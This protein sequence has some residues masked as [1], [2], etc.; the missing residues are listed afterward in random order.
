MLHR[1]RCGIPRELRIL[2][3]ICSLSGAKTRSAL[4]HGSGFCAP[5]K[6][7][8]GAPKGA[9]VVHSRALAR[10][11]PALRQPV[12]LTALHCGVIRWWD[13]SA[14]PACPG[15]LGPDQLTRRRDGRFHPGLHDEPGGLLHT[16][17]GSRLAK[18]ARG[19][20]SPFTSRIACRTPLKRTGRSP[21]YGNRK[22]QSRRIMG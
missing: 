13:P 20:P 21:T 6:R 5:F 10:H 4:L 18:P 7:G 16:S 22:F 3:S 19:A 14:P 9:M 1:S 12:R 15:S 8:S 2:F 11:A 17:P